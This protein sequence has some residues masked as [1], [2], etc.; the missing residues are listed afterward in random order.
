MQDISSGC[1]SSGLI[2]CAVYLCYK[3]LVSFVSAF[4]H[5]RNQGAIPPQIFSIS[6]HFVLWEVVSLTKYCC[7]PQAKLFTPPNFWAGYT[8]RHSFDVNTTAVQEDY[9][10][11]LKYFLTYYASLNI[12]SPVWSGAWRCCHLLA[13]NKIKSRTWNTLMAAWT[14]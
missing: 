8:P 10:W 4:I 11:F 1:E 6:S 5:R 12:C 2:L 14:C 9:K 13:R 7:S 3:P